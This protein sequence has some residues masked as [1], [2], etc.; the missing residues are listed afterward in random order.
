MYE[1]IREELDL[2]RSAR[3]F[4]SFSFGFKNVIGVVVVG[5]RELRPVELPRVGIEIASGELH[6]LLAG[7]YEVGR[8]SLILI[9][10]V[11][12]A[13]E[14]VRG[15]VRRDLIEARAKATLKQSV[16]VS[17][18]QIRAADELLTAW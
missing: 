15:P 13:D 7:G 10:L 14:T 8:E 9:E 1:E 2:W 3:S 11:G 16:N 12:Y 18:S 6:H 17:K 4:S 5:F